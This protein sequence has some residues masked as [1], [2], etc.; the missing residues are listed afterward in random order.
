M[1][2]PCLADGPACGTHFQTRVSLL[3]EVGR[4]TQSVSDSDFVSWKRELKLSD[5]PHE[6]MALLHVWLGEYELAKNQEPEKAIWHFRQARRLLPSSHSIAGLAQYDTAV[7]LHYEGAYAESATAFKAILTSKTPVRGFDRRTCALFLRHASA[8]AGYHAQRAKMGIPEPKRLD[9]LCGVSQLAICLRA[10]GMPYDKA[11]ASKYC[12]YT[13]EG[14]SLQDIADACKKLGLNGRA[15][16]A[17]EK[18]L[19]ALPKPLIAHVEHDHFVTVV[20]ADKSGVSYIC[21]DCGPW[22]G[23][24][25]DLTWK[26]WR[27]LEAGLYFS[28]AKPGC[29]NDRLLDDAFG[30]AS[31]NAASARLASRGVPS[32]LG[33][34]LS[35]L[36]MIKSHAI[37]YNVPY[38]PVQCGLKPEGSHCWNCCPMDCSGGGGTG[39]RS[40]LGASDGDPVNLATGE[41]EYSPSPDLTVYNPHG[42]SITW[43]RIYNSLRSQGSEYENDDFGMGWSHPYN[44]EVYDPNGNPQNTQIAPGGNAMVMARGTDTCGSGLTWDIVQYGTTI[45]TSSVPNGWTV[46]TLYYSMCTVTVPSGAAAGV[47]YEV[48]WIYT[49]QPHSGFFDVT[50]PVSVPQGGSASFASTGTEAPGTGLTWDITY[51]GSTV[52]TSAAANGWTVT[53][54]TNSFTI[55]AP[56]LATIGNN[57]K[58]RYYRSSPYPGNLSAYFNVVGNRYYP[59]PGD[60]Y[61]ILENGA[62]V[63][64]TLPSAPTPGNPII[65]CTVTAGAP[66]LVDLYY[67]ASYSSGYYVITHKNRAKWIT[68]S[69]AKVIGS[70]ALCYLLGSVQDQVGNA[71]NFNYGN[72]GAGGFPMLST[73][74]DAS[75]GSALLSFS[76]SSNGNL[77]SVSD[78]YNR[79]VY[80]HVGTYNTSV[81][82]PYWQSY[83]EVDSVSQ[84]VTT[85]TSSPPS[86]WTYA[87]TN[88]S[89][90]EGTEAVPFLTGITVPSPTGTGNATATIAYTP[91]TCYVSSVTDANGNQRVYTAVGANITRVDVKNPGGTIVYSYTVTFNGNMSPTGRTDGT[92]TNYV[93]TEYYSDPNDPYKPSSVVDGNGRTT[94]FTWDQYGN[95]LTRTTNKGTVT[96]NTFDYTAF[97]LGKLTSTHEGSKT[98]TAFTYYE[99]SGLIQ[100][101]DM[102]T[103]GTSGAGTTVRTSF[104]Y[105]SLGN[106]LTVTTPGNNAATSITTTYNYTTDG[107]YSQGAALGQPILVTNNLGKSSHFRY[108]ARGNRTV[109]I[110]PLGNETD[111]ALNLANQ[112]TVIIY[113]LTGQSGS[114]HASTQFVYQYVGGPTSAVRAYDESNVNIRT[115]NYGYGPEGEILTRTGSAE[116]VTVTYDAAYRLKSLADGKSQTTQYAFNTAGYLNLITY[117]KGD[118][119]QFTAYDNVGNVTQRTDG[120]GIITNYTFGDADGLLTAI[121]YPAYGSQ[122]VSFSYDSYRRRSTMA[123]STGIFSCGFDDNNETTSVTTTYTGLSAKTISYTYYNNGSRSGMSTPAG[124]FSYSFDGDGRMISLGNPYAETTTWTYLDNG[125]PWTQTLGNNAKTTYT[126]NAWGMLSRVLNQT[127]TGTILSDFSNLTYNGL[128]YLTGLNVSIPAVPA[129]GG[130]TSL[131]FDSKG[132]LTQEASTRAGGYTSNFGCDNAGNPTTFKGVGHSF[133]SDNQDTA[134]TFDNNGNPTTYKGNTLTFDVENRMMAYGSTLAATYRGD[135]LR[136]STLAGGVRTYFLYDGKLPVVELD[137][138]GNVTAVNSFGRPGLVSRRANGSSTF[139]TFD[140]VGSVTQRLDSGQNVLSSFVFDAFGVGVNTGAVDCFGFGARLGYYTDLATGLQSLQFRCYDAATGRFA[141]RDPAGYSVGGPN[142]YAYCHNS[143]LVFADPSG[144][145]KVMVCF[146]GMVEAPIWPPGFGVGFGSWGDICFGLDLGNGDVGMEGGF[147]FGPGVGAGI[148]FGPGVGIGSGGFETGGDWGFG[149]GGFVDVVA[150]GGGSFFFGNGNASCGFHKS[151]EIEGGGGIGVASGPA[152]QFGINFSDQFRHYVIEPINGFEGWMSEQIRNMYRNLW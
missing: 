13:G 94:S 139:Y 43:R 59:K 1:L 115:V 90:G 117:P 99:P 73:I 30:T 5:P 18:G 126:L 77:T 125:W 83:Q 105:D 6:R 84:I 87:Y 67:S 120:R 136:A 81:P 93:S 101:V 79:S 146:G 134:S 131:T 8:C 74:T 48:R 46:S 26:Q 70:S 69:L 100:Y 33:Q 145:L 61:L 108:D 10:L 80:Y 132:Q 65:H 40:A 54:P 97:A 85:G 95:M 112:T 42:P 109:A 44:I 135:N 143:P 12:N 78:A 86:R 16:K 141:N 121:A 28:I 88:V 106:V 137:S 148:G 58:V 3:D 138:T 140:Q 22:P 114:G 60:K 151:C 11:S 23:G 17:D 152:F 14:S 71:I 96:T 102:P 53:Y 130:T 52:A 41:E 147:G 38:L 103:P 35:L 104:T 111:T 149:T 119:L 64:F 142:L 118:T 91:N 82:P 72:A 128:G 68:T 113:P 24:R 75:T 122:N 45:A 7:A 32:G 25:V 21:S 133:N 107:L 92:N 124:S 98:S 56:L 66:F 129:Y 37:L 29:A 51:Q 9:P 50:A 116:P 57:Y 27:A 55:G 2:S 49:S 110:D 4:F 63:L 76:R 19:I 47:N 89:N 127:S 123:D 144:L 15:I 150:G 36:A 34:R 31:A 39:V 62:R 20:R